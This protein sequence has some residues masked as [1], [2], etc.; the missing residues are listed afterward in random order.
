MRFPAQTS[1]FMALG[2]NE[3][4]GVAAGCKR[5][6]GLHEAL[7][8]HVVTPINASMWTWEE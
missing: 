1:V 6:V 8:T 4:A 5:S 7:Q 2:Q 3:A